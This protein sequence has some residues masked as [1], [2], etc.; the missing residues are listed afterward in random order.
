MKKILSLL[1]V[2]CLVIPAFAFA[3]LD[4]EE[5]EI[6]EIVEEID[7]DDVPEPAASGD[8]GSIEM[9]DEMADELLKNLE[10]GDDKTATIDSSSLYI[11][12]NM[13]EDVINILLLGVDTREDT[14]GED[15]HTVKR[16]DVQ[17]ILSFNT[18]TGDLKLTSIPR[19]T[20]VTNP[21]NGKLMPITNAY[22]S[23]D[24]KGVF[25]ENPQ[26]SI[27]VVN[28][29]FEMNIQY[30]FSINFY[31][32]VKIVEALGGVDVDLTEA[33]AYSINVYLS[34]R[35]I[36][37]GDKKVSHGNA[38]LKTYG[39]EFGLPEPLEV[40]AGVQHL[41][42]LQA[43][44]YARLRE[45]IRKKYPLGG[46]WQRTVRTRHLLELLLRKALQLKTGDLLNLLIDST[47]YMYTNM[48]GAEI[49]KLAMAA[50]DSG[51]MAKSASGTD[52]LFEQFRVPMEGTWSY[53]NGDIFISRNNGN[54]QKNIEALHGF[55]YGEGN[56]YPAN[57]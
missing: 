44:I 56:Y 41:T 19:D 53:S 51:L 28:Y 9:T 8:T 5:L 4:E 55:I 45:T 27:A 14:L 12:P 13:P 17:L 16:A 35:T 36:K 57:P 3:E 40:K 34:T 49:Y 24:D 21:A 6:E 1:L 47:Q 43:L 15:D 33:E 20:L 23:F 38:I 42:G 29:N 39:K 10:A 54:F 30:F 18:K 7:L 11:N 31:G 32:V 46:D 26:R 52:S 2:L 50:L 48:T 37:S 22:T 25:H